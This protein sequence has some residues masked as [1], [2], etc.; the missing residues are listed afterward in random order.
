MFPPAALLFLQ[1]PAQ[2]ALLSVRHPF[3]LHRKHPCTPNLPFLFYPALPLSSVL[4]TIYSLHKNLFVYLYYLFSSSRVS[5]VMAGGFVLRASLSPVHGMG[6]S[7]CTVSVV[8]ELTWS[9]WPL[10]PCRLPDISYC[11]HL[12]AP[13]VVLVFKASC[14]HPLCPNKTWPLDASQP[15]HELL[16]TKPSDVLQCCK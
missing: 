10:R 14:V 13:S 3:P 8:K 16:S 12:T 2:I 15:Q 7:R 6:H 4:T 5:S 11:G 9:F 1:M